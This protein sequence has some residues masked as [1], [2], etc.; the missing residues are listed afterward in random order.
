MDEL[1]LEHILE[2]YKHPQHRGVPE[3]YDTDAKG[4]NPSCGDHLH[5][6][7]TYGKRDTVEDVQFEGDGCAISVAAMDLLSEKMKGMNKSDVAKLEARDI[8]EL[9][10]VEVGPGREKCALLSLR[11]I[12][13]AL[14][15]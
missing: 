2:H 12:K 3:T 4:E 5:V 7:I 13:K 14:E 8:H 1:Y 9:L 15:I 11:T 6:Y 10:K